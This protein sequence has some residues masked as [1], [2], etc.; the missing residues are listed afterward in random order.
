MIV[1]AAI[2]PHGTPAFAPGPTRDALEEIGRRFA[3]AA[4]ETIVVV[5]PHNVHMSG[6]FAV[7]ATA[8]VAG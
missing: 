1:A 8:T 5:T 3:A 4:P 7:V 6:D 2:A